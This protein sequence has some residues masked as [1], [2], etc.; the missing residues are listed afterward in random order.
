MS[1]WR[2]QNGNKKITD[3]N[4]SHDIVPLNFCDVAKRDLRIYCNKHS[5]PIYVLK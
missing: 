2:N 3:T 1:H 5:C 4:K